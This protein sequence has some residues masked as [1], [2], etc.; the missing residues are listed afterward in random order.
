M[1]NKNCII[2]FNNSWGEV[3]FILPILKELKEKKYKIY[4]SFKNNNLLKKKNDYKDL[5][6]LLLNITEII[7]PRNIKSKFKI[8]NVILNYLLRPK[9]FFTKIKNF[10][11][12]NL[13]N[14]IKNINLDN[15]ENHLKYLEKNEIDLDFLLFADFDTD[16]YLWIK[17]YKNKKFYLFPHAISLRGNHLNKFRN[18]KKKVFTR[19]FRRRKFLLEKF[20]KN[21]TLFACNQDELNHFKQFSP[22]NIKLKVL[23]YP[24]LTKK[25]INFM[26]SKITGNNTI[27]NHKK[28]ILLV[29]GKV[30]YLGFNEIDK[31]IK[32]VIKI[33]DNFDYNIL[34]KDHPRNN[35]N[36]SIY[37]KFSNK[38]S[39][40]KSELSISSALKY[41]QIMILTSKSGV[42]LEGVFQK[43][44]VIEYYKYHTR[45]FKNNTYEY[46]IDGKMF[47]IF[48]YFNLANSCE[49]FLQL[50]RFI[51]LL[52]NYKSFKKK[53]ILKQN[54][55]L[56]KINFFNEQK[57]N[58]NLIQ[59]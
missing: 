4:T 29:I 11:I 40:R 17:K 10:N 44:I 20:P 47:S 48:K 3:D 50:K 38:I 58:I 41:C 52:E 13:N 14:Y 36:F 24:R 31:K 55:G 23:G 2:I 37:K 5:Y 25:W 16:N 21:T 7:K 59:N 42:C 8:F 53:I 30:S 27:N 56:N 51:Y 26:H 46:L 1:K 9:Y 12:F 15:S 32:E 49:N 19:D 6:S 18:V 34:I 39:I 45:N 22:K 28:N 35:I 33:A 54:Q 57:F 43:K